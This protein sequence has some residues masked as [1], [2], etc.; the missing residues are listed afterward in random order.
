MLCV[1]ADGFISD[2][3][4]FQYLAGSSQGQGQLQIIHKKDEQLGTHWL[5]KQ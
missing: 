4:C 3:I 2:F 1:P 5:G